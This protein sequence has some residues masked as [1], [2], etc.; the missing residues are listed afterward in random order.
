[1]SNSDLPSG[2]EDL[3]QF[4]PTWALKGQA[5]RA[6]KLKNCDLDELGR[7]YRA[8]LPRLDAI[9]GHLNRFPLDAMP[10]AEQTLMDVVLTF[11][12]TA[13]PADLN[14]KVTEQPG[15]LPFERFAFSG[16]SERW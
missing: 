4:V 1:M 10:P 12:E 5:A 8:V 2:F 3:A 7:F 13:Y 6:R 16:A 15:I 11:A 9:V 14:W